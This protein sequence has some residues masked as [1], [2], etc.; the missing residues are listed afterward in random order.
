MQEIFRDYSHRGLVCAFRHQLPLHNSKQK[1]EGVPPFSPLE[2]EQL[3]IVPEA[4][5]GIMEEV[6]YL[7][8]SYP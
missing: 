1:R 2:L 7:E 5:V 6:T 3:L 8:V 4:Q